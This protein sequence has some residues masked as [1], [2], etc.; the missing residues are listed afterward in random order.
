MSAVVELTEAGFNAHSDTV[1]TPNE[2]VA[3]LSR[4]WGP[5]VLVNQPR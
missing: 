4:F 5:M 2:A 1:E 3:C